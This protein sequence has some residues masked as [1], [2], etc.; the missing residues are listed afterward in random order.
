MT[1]PTPSL[2][3]SAEHAVPVFDSRL[4]DEGLRLDSFLAAY[5]PESPSSLP[6]LQ[7]SYESPSSI[8]ATLGSPLVEESPSSTSI[9]FPALAFPHVHLYLSQS[10]RNLSVPPSPCPIPVEPQP[11]PKPLDAHITMTPLSGPQDDDNE[12]AE[13]SPQVSP[14]NSQIPTPP[15][16]Y[17]RPMTAEG[18]NYKPWS[19]KKKDSWVRTIISLNLKL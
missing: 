17:P 13:A 19:D 5:E 8:T 18:M 16:P 15:P 10:P 2:L 14:S 3:L 9:P 12:M 1:D 11:E 6:D 7:Y 4:T